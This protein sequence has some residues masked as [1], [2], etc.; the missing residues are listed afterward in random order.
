M[1]VFTPTRG[2]AQGDVLS[3]LI[4]VAV[5][6]IFLDALALAQRPTLYSKDG[7]GEVQGTDEVAYIRR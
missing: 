4:W 1:T 7:D 6:D 2:I 3:P 5:F